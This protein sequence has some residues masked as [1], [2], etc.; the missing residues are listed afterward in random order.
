MSLH[1]TTITA[2]FS[3]A[4]GA[5]L[6]ACATN[7]S[8]QVSAVNVEDA[9]AS[10]ARG[11]PAAYSLPL[12]PPPKIAVR[13]PSNDTRDSL[14]AWWDALGDPMLSSFVQNALDHNQDLA[15]AVAKLT[16]ARASAEGAKADQYPTADLGGSATR[17]R[18]SLADPAVRTFANS[19]G[20]QRGSTTVRTDA[21]LNWE[22]DLFG[23]RAALASASALRAHASRADQHAIRLTLVA[24][25]ARQTVLARSLQQKVDVAR[26]AATIETEIVEITRAKL[27]GGQIS[28][29]DL[30]RAQGL[31]QDSLAAAA[32]LESDLG[33]AIQALS[34]LLAARPADIRRRIEHA[35]IYSIEAL[36]SSALSEIA[37]RSVPADLLRR[38]PDVA[39]AELQLA[40]ASRELSATVAERFPRVNL[41]TTLALVAS[42][43][44]G[45]GSANAL[46][47]S[48][49]PSIT[50][51]AFDGGRLDADISRAKGAEQEALIKYQQ[52]V[53]VAFAEA[54][55]AVADIARRTLTASRTRASVK[56]QSQAWDVIRLQYE[57]GL[58]DLS[59]A[60]DTKRGL[61]RSQDAYITA[62]Q[63]Q[64]LATITMYRALAGGW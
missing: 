15:V 25:V 36:D 32:R 64:M 33:E 22:I 35:K 44:S 56:A 12:Q 38:R 23:R 46:L 63:S 18:R 20:F 9:R 37:S 2:L 55:T 29:A 8:D 51:R 16:Q 7:P 28:Q 57:R 42:A 6:S 40:A 45:L 24:E 43:V 3:I 31:E 41:G 50:W 49:A 21:N 47:A 30:L 48:V 1:R 11:L 13:D 5:V 39:R 59:A 58:V 61:T 62:Q 10:A 27:R 19:P 26:E 14:V 17:T 54:E 4:V 52:S 53:T 34:V 60:L